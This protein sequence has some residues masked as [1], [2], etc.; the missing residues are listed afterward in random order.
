MV[1]KL[2]KQALDALIMLHSLVD[3]DQMVIIN[4]GK[5]IKLIMYFLISNLLAH[6]REIWGKKNTN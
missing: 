4:S 6:L 1:F 3:T 5:N 2:Q